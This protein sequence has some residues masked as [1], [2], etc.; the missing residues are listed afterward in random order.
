MKV[1][2][3]ICHPAHVHFFRNV[4]EI[5]NNQYIETIVI[6]REKDVAGK[7]LDEYGIKHTPIGG[8]NSGSLFGMFTELIVRDYK[9]SAIVKKNKP[10]ILAAV[11]GI[12]SAHAGFL[13]RTRSVVF[14]DTEMAKLQNLLTYPFA[15]MVAVPNCYE[16]W[17]PKK[18]T[19][20]PGLHELSYLSPKYFHA[21][22]EIAVK[23]G[24]QS[25]SKNFLIRLVSWSANHDI[26]DSGWTEALLRRVVELL[27]D[28][29][30]VI[31]SSEDRLPDNLEE[32]AYRGEPGALHHLLAF[33]DLY[34]G[35]SATI[36][37]E[38]AVLGVRSIYAANS[39]RGYCTYLEKEYGLMTNLHSLH[40][41]SVLAC[42]KQ[43]L[44]IPDELIVKS[45]KRFL[46]ETIDVPKFV[47]KLLVDTA[48]H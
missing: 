44:D 29:G 15:S 2:I 36:A 39:K 5:L 16:G 20:Y 30:N 17:L 10:D 8:A 27:S 45:N 12:F 28:Q 7:L 46:E 23:A 47:A 11:G 4:I 6:S 14:Y 34:V 25:N 26:G 31:I 19:K 38:A 24:I 48:S 40:S 18:N 33:C 37:S 3:D 35:E 1:L 32:Y 43:V 22:E 9:L 42:I 41:G 13:T 21:S